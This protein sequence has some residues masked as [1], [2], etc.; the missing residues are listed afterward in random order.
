MDTILALSKML[1]R[2]NSKTDGII[3]EFEHNLI[4]IASSKQVKHEAKESSQ[5]STPSTWSLDGIY[6]VGFASTCEIMNIKDLNEGVCY[7]AD[8]ERYKNE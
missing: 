1:M 8:I 2:F 7:I 5:M 3:N 6:N 4:K